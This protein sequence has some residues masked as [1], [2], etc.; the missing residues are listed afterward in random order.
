M[1]LAH[2]VV[3]ADAI[4]KWGIVLGQ[5]VRTEDAGLYMA[6]KATSAITVGQAVGIDENFAAA[7][8]TKAMTDDGWFVG[9]AQTAKTKDYYGWMAMKG[10]N[11]LCNLANACA[12]DVALYTTSTAGTLDDET[13]GQ[14]KIDGVVAVVTVS[15]SG[16][17]PYE[18]IATWPRSAGL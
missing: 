1:I 11:I 3:S 7:P 12:K 9:F 13:S 16:K 10:S 8:L 6:V 5:E 17:G 18:V 14:T 15:A 2:D 4:A